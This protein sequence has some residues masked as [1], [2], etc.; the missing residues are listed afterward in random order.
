VKEAVEPT[1]TLFEPVIL[2]VIV[3]FV[4]VKLAVAVQVFAAVAVTV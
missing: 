3:V 1:Q 2:G 4:S